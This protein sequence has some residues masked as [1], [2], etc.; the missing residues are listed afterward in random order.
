MLRITIHDSAQALTFKLEGKLAGAWVKELEQC[1]VT[2]SS[3]LNGRSVIVDLRKVAFIDPEGK[4]LLRRMKAS[5][6][7][8]QACSPLNCA[9]V[10]DISRH[11]SALLAF[12]IVLFAAPAMNAQP[13]PAPLRLTLKDAVVLALKQNPQ[14]QIANLNTATAQEET[15][16]A[17]AGLLPQVGLNSGERVQR[18]NMQALLGRPFPGFPQHAGPFETFQG[19]STFSAPIFDLTLW[20][21]Y[22]AAKSTQKATAEQANAVREDL[23]AMVVSQYLGS[24]RAQAD[25]DAAQSRA[26]L[27]QAL[28]TQAADLQNSG[29]GTGIDTLR[30]NVELQNEKQ[31]LIASQTSLKTS[32]FGLARLLSLPPEQPVELADSVSFFQTPA[33][34]VDQTV[35]AAL[36]NRPE[37]RALQFRAEAA[38][39]QR[40][41]ASAARLPSVHFDGN[42]GYFGLSP[43]TSIPTYNYGVGVTL[44]LF[45]GG[46]ISAERAQADIETRRIEQQRRQTSDQIALEVKTSAAQLESARGEVDVANLSVKLASEEVTQA[47]DRFQA[48][49]AT[50]V[51]V[52][53][54]QDA[55]ARANDNQIVA[56]YRYNQAR[57]DLAR[58]AGQIENIYTK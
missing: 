1:W 9:I 15:N 50:N 36:A 25:V 35:A 7:E 54:A 29:V 38:R 40:D 52:I 42:W 3:T 58:A 45:T 18:I 23:A 32:L 8:M 2:G 31:R 34:E 49:V 5:G 17:R 51:E 10:D 19:A 6:A 12:M 39:N 4:E 30:A 46:R 48:G 43:Q 41:E 44:P 13:D 14:V 26:N 16:I 20:H 33:I 27:A 53:Q 56:L 28:Y 22:R 21:R 11:G 55:L 37:I 57:A 24:L 47:R